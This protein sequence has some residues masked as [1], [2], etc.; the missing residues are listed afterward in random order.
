M[1]SYTSMSSNSGNIDKILS[2]KLSEDWIDL[3]LNIIQT[4]RVNRLLFALIHDA[5]ELF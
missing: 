4:L 2:F 1:K 3:D 5:Q